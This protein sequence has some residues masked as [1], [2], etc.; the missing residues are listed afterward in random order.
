MHG[1]HSHE[2]GARHDHRRRGHHHHEHPRGA[3]ARDGERDS[4]RSG[5]HGFFNRSS[6]VFDHGDLR[7]V[8]LRLLADK[9]SHGYELIKEI[10]DRLAGAYSPS[11]GSVY[12]TLSLLEDLGHI[13]PADAAAAG[14]RKAYAITEEGR[15]ALER[16]RP[17]VDVIFGKIDQV[18]ARAGGGVSPR[19]LRALEGVKLALRLRLHRGALTEAQITD[20]VAALEAA[21]R[22]IEQD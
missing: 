11:P 17:E 13:A 22:T 4:D 6:R 20:A 16:H 8:V 3:D 21:A 5:R 18:A 12:P 7:W 2:S 15:A 10:E 19:I 1:T 14:A 9:P